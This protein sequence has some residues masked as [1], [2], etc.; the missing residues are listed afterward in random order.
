MVD[1]AARV[2]QAA[3]QTPP[4]RVE[5][6]LREFSLLSDAARQAFLADRSVQELASPVAVFGQVRGAWDSLTRL[7]A[8]VP[9]PPQA[10][11]LFLGTVAG[12][13][14][15]VEGAACLTLVWALKLLHP[16]HVVCTRGRMDCEQMV[17]LISPRSVPSNLLPHVLRVWEAL[18]PAAVVDG[19]VFCTEGGFSPELESMQQVLE[20]RRPC[21]MQD[22][23]LLTD[24][25]W[26]RFERGT[27]GWN[28][29]NYG[30]GYGFGPDIVDQMLDKLGMRLWI[31]SRF[32]TDA[33]DVTFKYW[34]ECRCACVFSTRFPNLDS[35]P[36]VLMLSSD[37]QPVRVTAP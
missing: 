22:E 14:A 20:L 8:A 13:G 32:E 2:V 7:L 35:T 17:R 37:L 36:A 26:G 23:G 10:S 25:L 29:S 30:A 18:P 11:L 33:D 4:Q 15:G 3:R 19:R 31:F 9:A 6:T 24:L 28:E 1:L 16:Q 27:P 12:Y 21:G 34:P 5:L